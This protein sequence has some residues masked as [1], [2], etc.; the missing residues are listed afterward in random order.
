MSQ[1]GKRTKLDEIK[2]LFPEKFLPEEK[3]FSRI[4]RGDRIF[5]GTACAEPQYLVQALTDYAARNPKAFFD[6]RGGQ[7]GICPI[8]AGEAGAGSGELQ[9]DGAYLGEVCD[10]FDNDFNGLIDDGLGELK[11]AGGKTIPACINGIPQQCPADP[12][13]VCFPSRTRDLVSWW[14]WIH[15]ARC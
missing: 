4:N 6:V 5:I 11:C 8:C 14:C 3:V 13:R 1:E 7:G 12:Q 15:R 9:L 2:K 10:G